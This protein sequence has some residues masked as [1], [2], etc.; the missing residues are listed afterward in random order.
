MRK[1]V[2]ELG[3]KMATDIETR[4]DVAKKLDTYMKMLGDIAAFTN[5]QETA[6]KSAAA[7]YP[8][9]GGGSAE[10]TASSSAGAS[11][12]SG[13]GVIKKSPV[14]VASQAMASIK[15]Q[16]DSE[17]QG[18]HVFWSIV[19][20]PLDFIVYVI[21]MEASCELQ[22]LWEGKVL[23]ETAHIPANKL[24]ENLFGKSG[25]VNKF[26]AAE[27]KP[28]LNRSTKGWSSRSWF[29][30]PFPFRDE[31]FTFLDDGARGSQEIQ[32]EYKV[33]LSTL[34]TAVNSNATEEPIATELAVECGSARQEL[35]NYNYAEDMAFTW[36]PDDCGTTTLTIRFPGLD[37][38]RTYEGQ[39]GFAKF[40]GEFRNGVKTFTPDDF[41]DQKKGLVGLG[42]SSIK[43]GYKI[44]GAV[45]IIG[46]LDIKPLNVPD[47]ITDCWEH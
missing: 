2:S 27:A 29:G 28:F 23:A 15:V 14:E 19:G 24:R 11:S 18:S 26:T 34:P 36:K 35:I 1:I 4:I 40:L 9:A 7:L 37:L 25:V 16:M 32:P 20:G 45:P 41:P 31:F 46:L 12:K 22:Q 6:Y 39:L 21:T 3:G 44:Q 38:T 43:V 30:I 5:T 13:P 47:I 17:G 10:A 33:T 42:V 8:G